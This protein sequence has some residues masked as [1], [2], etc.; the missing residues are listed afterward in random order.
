MTRKNI[1]SHP[2][3]LTIAGSDS[4]SGAGI[5]A[6]LRTFAAFGVF[7]VNAITAVT[8]QNPAAIKKIHPVPSSFVI[9]QCEAVFAKFAIRAVKTGMLHNASTVR[10][11]S[12]FLEK[13]RGEKKILVVDPV[14][15]ASSGTALL[16][17]NALPVIREK[18]FPIADVITPNIPEAQII[19]E[20]KISDF[21]DAVLAAEEIS[22]KWNCACVLKGGHIEY[23]KGIKTDIFSFN[24]KTFSI[25]S[26]AVK[27]NGWDS[28]GT[29]CVFSAAITANLAKNIKLLDAVCLAKKFIIASLFEKI[30]VGRDINAM[31]P[32]KTWE[33][34]K[35]HETPVDNSLKIKKIR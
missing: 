7:G 27:N 9:A 2:A 35:K 19:L 32:R 12:A 10:A 15:T 8:A 16:N 14:I 11:V 21:K 30:R 23:E 33:K 28:H 6:D 34:E 26:A 5:Q 24:G 25:S 18:L 13:R 31:F 29:G 3:A 22:S 20:E 17:K 4:G 1:F